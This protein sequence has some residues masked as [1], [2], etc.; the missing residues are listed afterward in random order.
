MVTLR[1]YSIG[2]IPK[3]TLLKVRIL[4]NN[5]W[6]P[7][8]SVI[9]LGLFP[10]QIFV[11]KENLKFKIKKDMSLYRCSIAQRRYFCPLDL[12]LTS[13]GIPRV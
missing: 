4:Q 8:H 11:E 1:I 10:L 6:T 3:M 9:S 13:E 7:S 5:F 12:Q 2:S